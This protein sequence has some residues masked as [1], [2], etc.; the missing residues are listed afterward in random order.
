MKKTIVLIGAGSTVFTPGLLADLVRSPVFSDATVR[1]VDIDGAAVEVMVALGRR[2]AVE[3]GSA[4]RVEGTT[5]RREALPGADFVTTTV[6]VGGAKGWEEDIAIPRRHGVDQTVGDTVGP[7]G[8]LRALRQVPELVSIAED[9]VDLA[10]G[11]WLVN[12]ANPLTTNVRAIVA[13]TGARVI[14]LCHGTM[15]TTGTLAAGLG[16]PTAQI[17]A[18]FAGVN[19]LCW[20]TDLRGAGGEDLYPKLRALV[21]E[22]AT[23]SSAPSSRTEG[24]HQAVSADLSRIFGL[25]PAPGDRHVAE[26]FP[27]YLRGRRAD[28]TLRWGLQGG[29]DRTWEYIKGKETLWERLRAEAYESAPLDP[30]LLDQGREAE[31]LVTI[32]E[33]LATGRESLELAVNLTNNG[34]ISGLPPEAVVEVPAVIGA[35]GI[36][37]V[38]VGALPAGIIAVLESRIRQQELT[39]TAALTFDRASALTALALDPLIPDTATARAIL[40]EGLLAHAAHLPAGWRIT[41]E[42]AFIEPFDAVTGAH[43]ETASLPAHRPGTTDPPSDP[44][45]GDV[46]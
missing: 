30:A 17:R 43:Q 16:M 27:W 5:D 2:L 44:S 26:F 21:A 1:L 10:P 22:R 38:A 31:R 40:S 32:I 23:G 42:A 39:V 34:A 37:P 4:L 8:F 28:G 35:E 19:H 29:Q 6:A 15:H 20:L 25:Y 12:Y 24:V 33:S 7:G 3:A 14:G 41:P 11:A 45:E 46:Q 18:T 13:H 9:I 36:R